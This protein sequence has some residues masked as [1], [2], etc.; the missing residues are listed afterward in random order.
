MSNNPPTVFSFTFKRMA[1]LCYEERKQIRK[2]F[3][4]NI[5]VKVVEE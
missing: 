1:L 4:K 2:G 3:L 5:E